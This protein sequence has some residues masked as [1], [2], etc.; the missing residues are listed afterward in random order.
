M[1]AHIPGSP[2]MVESVLQKIERTR[3]ARKH[4]FYCEMNALR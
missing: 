3:Q 1:Q 2:D 4:K